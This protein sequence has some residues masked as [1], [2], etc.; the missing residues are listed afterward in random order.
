MATI[1]GTGFDN[2]LIVEADD[3]RGLAG[4]DTYIV[5]NSLTNSPTN[6]G[7]VV[8]INDTEGN[9]RL[10]LADGL[11]I[12]LA[13]FL[14]GNAIQL[15]LSNG[16]RIQVVGADRFAF[17]LGGNS[18]ADDA[19]GL[20]GRTFAQFAAD[21]GVTLVNGAGSTSG[22][23]TVQPG[24]NPVPLAAN[25]VNGT[26]D[27]D[28]LVG[29]PQADR[30][31]GL[32]GNDT[33]TGGLGNDTLDGGA[34]TM[35]DVVSYL[36]ASGPVNVNLAL[37]TATGADGNDTLLNIEGVRGSQFSDVLTGDANNNIFSGRGGDDTIDGGDGSDTATYQFAT[38]AVSVNLAINGVSGAEG[39]DTLL[40]IENVIGSDFDDMLLGN[41]GNNLLF[42]RGG[43]DTLNGSGGTD[44]ADY[45]LATGAVLV[46]LLTNTSSGADG[47]DTL[48]DIENL[49]GSAFSDTLDGS[50]AANTLEGGAGDDMLRGQGGNDSLFGGAGNDTLDGGAGTDAVSY[51]FALAGVVVDLQTG[52]ATG[53]DGNDTLIG[54]ESV[55]GSGFND[56]I[57]GAAGVQTLFGGAGNDVISGLAGSDIV[58]GGLGNDTLFGGTQDD[59]DYV[60]YT[61]AP[62]AVTVNL[63][64]GLAT[65]GDGNDTLS[66]F[67]GVFGSAFDDVITGATTNDYLRGN[68]GNDTIDGGTGIDRVDYQSATGAVSVSLLLGASTGADG[69]D[70]LVGIEDVT[71]SAFDDTLIGD[72]NANTL[73]GV[74]GD[75]TLNG[76]G[77]TDRADYISATG[78]VN[79]SLMTNQAT[80]ADG[81]DTLTSIENVRGSEFADT[82]TGDGND[83]L[84]DAR[85]GVDFV[86]GGDGNDTLLGGAGADVLG[87]G[88]GNDTFR[89]LSRSDTRDAAFSLADTTT[90]NMD[91]VSDFNGNGVGP[92]D[93][94][95]FSRA[96]LGANFANFPEGFERTDALRGAINSFAELQ[97]SFGNGNLLSGANSVIDVTVSSGSLAGRYLILNDSDLALDLVNADVIINITGAT[98]QIFNGDILF[99]A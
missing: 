46:S 15:T 8:V 79:V 84:L 18:V 74:G 7:G 10:Q 83:N 54:I 26:P 88:N 81:T 6:P 62:S 35:F 40:N 78:G 36:N 22:P 24:P 42:G 3:L 31:N 95:S 41:N 20:T 12:N 82:L 5:T 93:V 34:H 98:G 86:A 92:G 89:F 25:V 55:T 49:R 11:Q 56:I 90:A 38:G 27:N 91:R 52:Q 48:V 50:N 66:E 30:I 70:V 45:S 69:N 23:V 4:N 28:D 53:G 85:G 14:G 77:G 43:N 60:S 2:T 29:T 32:A 75:D 87:G 9:N 96:G 21:L 94:F 1:F 97:A 65:G 13:Q 72:N 99:T 73:R 33:L 17:D 16:L 63:A 19:V 68:R 59:F 67:E 47:Q 58:A 44:T 57:T 71:G 76:G 80:G 39:N 37:G 51:A 61:F 64:T